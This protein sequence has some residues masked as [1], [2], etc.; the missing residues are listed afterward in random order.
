MAFALL[1]CPIGLA[2][3]SIN[4]PPGLPERLFPFWRPCPRDGLVDAVG[5]A[6][7][8]LCC[9]SGSA[10]AA[11]L[12]LPASRPP[13]ATCVGDRAVPAPLL[14]LPLA[15]LQ[16]GPQIL[17]DRGW[18]DKTPCSR[19]LWQLSCARLYRAPA[20]LCLPSPGPGFLGAEVP[21][22]GQAV[23]QGS[24]GVHSL[25]EAVFG[26]GDHLGKGCQG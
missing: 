2:E 21:R 1:G 24:C 17:L 18:P 16:A 26:F 13:H 8:V 11:C 19:C 7:S 20:L 15:L 9:R 4:C 10:G 23:G 22:K 25:G 14:A 3:K 6:A 12:A 5:F